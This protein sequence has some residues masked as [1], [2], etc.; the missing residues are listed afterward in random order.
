[1]KEIGPNYIQ[2][3][4]DDYDYFGG[5][6]GMPYQIYYLLDT[7]TGERKT[8]KDFYKGS[9]ADFKKLVADATVEDWKKDKDYKYYELYAP[10][11]EA[12]TRENFES[13]VNF[14]MDID[15]SEDKITVYYPPYAVAPFASGFV[16]IDIPYS[17]LGFSL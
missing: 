15:F 5:A 3:L 9:E 11:E 17:E 14:D 10:S 13:Y 2:L 12:N 8:I 6:H 1:V 16:G 7:R 4:F